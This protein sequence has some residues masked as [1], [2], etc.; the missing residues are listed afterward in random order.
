MFQVELVL[1]FSVKIERTIRCQTIGRGILA[2]DSL[3]KQ[4]LEVH[5][6]ILFCSKNLGNISVLDI[7]GL[8]LLRIHIFLIFVNFVYLNGTGSI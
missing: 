6:S 8:I 7:W 2:A 1:I 5:R 4:A 3:C